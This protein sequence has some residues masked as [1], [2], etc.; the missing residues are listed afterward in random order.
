M[1]KD[2]IGNPKVQEG[3]YDRKNP[4][5]NIRPGEII[6]WEA[7]YGPNEGRLPLERL[8]ENPDFSEIKLGYC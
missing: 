6:L 5:K 8:R 2:P 3:V 7:H 1:G 4:G